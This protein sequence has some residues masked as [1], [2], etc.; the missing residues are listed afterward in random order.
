MLTNEMKHAAHMRKLELD[1]A[2][3]FQITAHIRNCT[4]C[5]IWVQS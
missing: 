3:R 5:W 1:N 4:A 2:T